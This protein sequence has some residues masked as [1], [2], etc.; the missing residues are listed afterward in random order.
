MW[1]SPTCN[2]HTNSTNSPWYVERSWS[3]K[4]TLFF[5]WWRHFIVSQSTYWWLLK[6][7]IVYYILYNVQWLLVLV[8]INCIIWHS[9]DLCFFRVFNCFRIKLVMRWLSSQ[10]TCSALSEA[11]SC[12]RVNIREFLT[13]EDGSDIYVDGI[14]NKYYICVL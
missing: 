5:D 2:L 3:L 10:A 13:C 6:L 1:Y 7:L 8:S 4:N 11:H 9:V 14:T 12:T